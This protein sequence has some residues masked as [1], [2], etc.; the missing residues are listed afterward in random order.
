MSGQR[1]RLRRL[2]A[3]RGPSVSLWASL[4]SDLQAQV[5]PE[6]LDRAAQGAPESLHSDRPA[7]ALWA[8]LARQS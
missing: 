8:F 3:E 6:A 1:S 5:T 2:E 7:L 4:P